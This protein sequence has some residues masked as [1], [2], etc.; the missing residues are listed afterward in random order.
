MNSEDDEED[1]SEEALTKKNYR[2]VAFV[3]PV[4][5]FTD[6]QVAA[7]NTLLCPDDRNITVRAGSAQIS[8]RKGAAA[9]VVNNGRDVAVLS[10]H[11]GSGAGVTVKI[12]GQIVVLRSGEQLLL[13]SSASSPASNTFAEVNP[14]SEVAVRNVVSHNLKS[15]LR[16][17]TCEFSIPSAMQNLKAIKRLADSAKKSERQTYAKMLK[18]AAALLTIGIQKGPYKSQKI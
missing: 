17:F 2:T 1:S 15:D 4:L 13:T 16:A 6:R 14:L 9:F 10:L 11:D 7:S 18:N 3:E 5:N 8:V 12:D